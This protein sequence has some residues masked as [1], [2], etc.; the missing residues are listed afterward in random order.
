MTEQCFILCLRVSLVNT[1]V[2]VRT[3]PSTSHKKREMVERHVPSTY[4]FCGQN[5]SQSAEWTA[6]HGKMAEEG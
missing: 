3:C 4:L 5:L 1:V 6:P 2:C